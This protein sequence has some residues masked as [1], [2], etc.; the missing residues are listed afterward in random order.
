MDEQPGQPGQEAGEPNPAKVG[1]CRSPANRRQAAIVP[2][3]EST[4]S[5]ASSAALDQ[6]GHVTSLLHGHGSDA[7]QWLPGL[8]AIVG[9][10]AQDENL[11]V[12][13]KGEVRRNNHPAGAIESCTRRLGQH[14]AQRRSIHSGRP[15]DGAW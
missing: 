4:R 7:R 10:V 2:V 13:G 3:P 6:I 12:A 11:G 8:V 14:P 15:Q 5:L 9:Q 1:D